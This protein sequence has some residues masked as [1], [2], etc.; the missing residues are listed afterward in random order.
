[1]AKLPDC[2]LYRLTNNLTPDHYFQSLRSDVSY[3]SM[4]I[5][6]NVVAVRAQVV[7]IL[8]NP[9][10]PVKL[11]AWSLLLRDQSF[12]PQGPQETLALP[13]VSETE[14]ALIV[15]EVV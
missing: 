11:E 12:I 4:H 9:M 6:D 1:M 3:F 10:S 14:V 13:N 5:Y 8:S 15:D 2:N 7:Y